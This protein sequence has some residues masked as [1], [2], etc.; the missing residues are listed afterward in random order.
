MRKLNLN[1]EKLY[2]IGGVVRDEILGEKSF[3]ID[4]TYQGDA[5]NFC[6]KLEAESSYKILQINEPFGTVKML[7]DNQEVDVASTRNE[8][9]ERKGH[10]PLVTEIGCDLKKDVL[11][12]DFTI[13]SLAKSLKTG[14]IIDYTG[15]LKDIKNKTLRVLHDGSFIDDPTRI[16]RGLKFSVRFGFNL[17]EHT[18]KLQDDYLNNVNYDMSYK[19]LKK[20]L[21]ETF[22]LNCQK[23]FNLFFG[24]N[25]YKL[26]TDSHITPPEFDIET[27][28][29][30]NP[31]KNIW[32]VYL[33][34]MNLDKLPLTKEESKIIE[35]F[36]TLKSSP[37][38]DNNFDIYKLFS[39]KSPESVLLYITNVNRETGMKYLSIK[40]ISIN[41]T[42]KDLKSIGIPPSAEYSKC[43][44]Y[45]LKHKLNNPLIKTED[46][47]KLAKKFF[48]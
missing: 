41:L 42:G 38:P 18:K 10:L 8:I 31:V 12:R 40:D 29:K 17:D 14:G 30:N 32:L 11:R 3:D 33:G 7:I 20:E 4:I 9:Y 1:D 36:K 43:F 16:V 35:D 2:Y 22:N 39:G 25:I 45:I 24:Q 21:I 5:V 27:L 44:D 37:A 6:K 19:R 46:E 34:W 48:S 13:N 47:L 28:I 15:G 23:A 26:L